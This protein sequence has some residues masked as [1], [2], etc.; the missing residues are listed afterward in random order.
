M[1]TAPI[2]CG[3]S[4]ARV[5][6]FGMELIYT[7]MLA[8][9]VLL[10][11]TGL[12]IG[13]MNDAAIFLTSAIASK[14]TPL[15]IIMFVASCG[16]IIGA[17]TSSGMM[18]VA[19]SGMFHPELFTFRE[20]MILYLSVM[21]ANIILLD[22]YNTLGLPTST[23][24]ALVFCLLGAAIA[25]STVQ[26]AADPAAAAADIGQYINSAR[27]MAIVAGIVLSVVIAFA[28]GAVVMY[29]SRLLFSFRYRRPFN[30]FGAAWCG[31]SVTAI[32]YFALFKGLRGV[33]A[34]SPVIQYVEQNLIFS[35]FVLW[36]ISSAV[37]FFLQRF[38]VNILKVNILAGTFA[39]ALAFA[40]ND[41]VNFIG[42]PVAGFDSYM[43][44]RQSGDTAM[45]MG[46]LAGPVAAKVYLLLGAAAV[47]ILTLWTS[48]R[49]L[50]VSR[51]ELSLSN[52][53]EVREQNG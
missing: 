47:M 22:I 1:R 31:I 32:I 34:H 3:P 6:T 26:I 14:E 35:L 15:R 2:T 29:L 45:H 38:K 43:L 18:E 42:V 10:A 53:S 40:G 46:A 37:L 5:K 23:T 33:L 51:T 25:A 20:V 39:L 9:M 30:R 48:R 11:V 7:F 24:V 52:Q 4:A 17:I 8:A 50:S 19:R 16:I 41:L 12:F 36:C 49:A 44:A 27:A 13:V 28:C 21:L